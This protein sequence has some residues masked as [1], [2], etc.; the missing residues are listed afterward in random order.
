M[1]RDHATLRRAWSPTTFHFPYSALNAG[2]DTD[3]MSA[4]A[5]PASQRRSSSNLIS[6]ATPSAALEAVGTR[7]RR[8]QRRPTKPAAYELANHAKAF[9]EGFQCGSYL[10][11]QTHSLTRISLERV[12]VPL[13]PTGS[14][15]IDLHT[16]PTLHWLPTATFT[17]RTR[18]LAHSL[19]VQ[20]ALSGEQQ[21]L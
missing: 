17:N 16:S 11:L 1:K 10:N 15:N 3:T 13:Q 5:V 21:R 6:N 19:Q 4:V 2:H 20:D 18:G 12:R 7:P 8:A 9:I 14:W